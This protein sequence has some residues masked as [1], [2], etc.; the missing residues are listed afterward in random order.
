MFGC[1]SDGTRKGGPMGRRD[2]P[3]QRFVIDEYELTFDLFL[4]GGDAEPWI[5]GASMVV[6]GDGGRR[7]VSGVSE[8]LASLPEDVEAILRD[9]LARWASAAD[10]AA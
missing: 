10:L 2:Y 5:I 9:K 3:G 4:Q 1:N 6:A 8:V 7:V